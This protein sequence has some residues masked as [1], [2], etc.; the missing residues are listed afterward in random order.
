[1]APPDKTGA[2]NKRYSLDELCG[3]LGISARTTRYYIQQGLVDRP[4]GQKRGAYYLEKH[5]RQLQ[6]IQEWQGAGFSLDRIRQLLEAGA[7]PADSLLTLTPR[8]GDVQVI[9]RIHIAPGVEL[10]INPE[11]AGLSP[12]QTR[13]LYR[14]IGEIVDQLEQTED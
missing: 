10:S 3:L 5:L 13:A 12:E 7:T 1:M 14:Q 2:N 11:Q 8:R 6:Q 4:E 9:S